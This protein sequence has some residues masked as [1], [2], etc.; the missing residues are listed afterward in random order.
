ME[1]EL[2]LKENAR[3]FVSPSHA[4]VVRLVFGAPVADEQREDKERKLQPV[5]HCPF[6][7]ANF[8]LCIP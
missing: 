6:S 4:L 7:I 5:L 1:P 8:T 3:E 2:K